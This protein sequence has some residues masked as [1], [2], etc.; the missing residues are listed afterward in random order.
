MRI[1][2]A[3][4]HA[5]WMM[6]CVGWLLA[7][8]LLLQ[9]ETIAIRPLGRLATSGT[10]S[11]DNILTPTGTV[12]FSGDHLSADNSPALVS[13]NSGGSVVLTRGAAATIS[14]K[15]TALLL[16]AEKGTIG[17]HFLPLEEARIEAGHYR[18]AISSISEAG[19]GELVTGTDGKIAVSLSSG[20]L[21]AFDT[22]SGEAFEVSAKT[23]S[24]TKL[25]PTGKGILANDANTLS[26]LTKSWPENSLKNKC[27]VVRGEAHRIMA[28]KSTSL[29]V[30]GTWLLFS[31]TYEY[32]ITDCT[33]QALANAE[34]AIGIEEAI[35]VPEAAAP[36]VPA[37][38][39]GMSS[40]AKAGIAIGV[41]GGAAAGIAVAVSNKSKSP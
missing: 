25:Q 10:I 23:Q 31:G 20:S 1:R 34:A 6:L 21:S 28:N 27:I 7:I 3:V 41:A 37:A 22:A 36:T 32:T 26:D 16:Q 12:F 9:G 39:K 38:S 18:F 13:L 5:V 2:P 35:A 4:R 24:E 29:T 17:F 15:G 40:G 14:R 30:R 19:V 8:P 33:E 11:V